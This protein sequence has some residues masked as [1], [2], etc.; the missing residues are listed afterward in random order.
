MSGRK[1]DLYHIHGLHD[2]YFLSQHQHK[3][4]QIDKMT[5]EFWKS[6]VSKIYSFFEF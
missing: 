1:T 5:D 4:D 6:N 2:D 3:S